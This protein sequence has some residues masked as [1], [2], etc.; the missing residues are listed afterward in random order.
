MSYEKNVLPVFTNNL[1]VQLA[2][3][4]NVYHKTTI[5]APKVLFSC[6]NVNFLRRS[7]ILFPL[8]HDYNGQ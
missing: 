7:D 8:H 6:K 1:N 3:T 2:D 4:L 5:S